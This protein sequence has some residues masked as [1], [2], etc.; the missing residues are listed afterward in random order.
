MYFAV[1]DL[2]YSEGLSSYGGGGRGNSGCCLKKSHNERKGVLQP[3]LHREKYLDVL[4]NL[5]ISIIR[6]QWTDFT[7]TKL[8][9]D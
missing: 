6:L 1:C 2:A 4:R 7:L 3:G 8:L 9:R 5:I